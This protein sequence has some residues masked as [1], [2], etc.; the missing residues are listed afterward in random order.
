MIFS[1]EFFQILPFW[2]AFCCHS[3][4]FVIIETRVWKTQRVSDDYRTG[5]LFRLITFAGWNKN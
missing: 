4:V 1:V 2:E 3:T 5:L